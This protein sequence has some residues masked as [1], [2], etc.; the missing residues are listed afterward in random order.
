[1]MKLVLSALDCYQCVPLPGQSG[2]DRRSVTC[3][4]TQSFCGTKTSK[5]DPSYQQRN[6]MNHQDCEQHQFSTYN[7]KCC[8]SNNCNS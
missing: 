2:C 1:V 8:Q 5:S 6:C 7:V 3:S 4:P